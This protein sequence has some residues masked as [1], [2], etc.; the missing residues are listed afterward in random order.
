M[1]PFHAVTLG[2]LLQTGVAYAWAPVRV[3]KPGAA[4]KQESTKKPAPAKAADADDDGDAPAATER[5]DGVPGG[6]KD[7][8]NEKICTVRPDGS[9]EFDI[10]AQMPK[11]VRLRF[12]DPIITFTQPDGNYFQV[13][14]RGRDMLLIV[15]TSDNLPDLT[16]IS[17]QTAQT[18]VTLHVRDGMREG[19]DALVSI[20]DPLKDLRSAER[21]RA[22]AEYKKI[23]RALTE[24]VNQRML[25]RIANDGLEVTAPKGKAIARNSDQIVVR[26]KEFISMGDG[27]FL[28]FTIQNRS[29]TT[30]EF[31]G[32]RLWDAERDLS[33]GSK[34]SR[35]T[36]APGEEVRGVVEFTPSP[37]GFKSLRLTVDSSTHRMVELNDIESP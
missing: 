33:A 8:K 37:N 23:E 27:R 25:D 29:N 5:E 16:P 30:F 6:C 28:V 32:A 36:I 2:L 4:K 7:G 21:Q 26:G 15:P 13:L 17:V 10:Y 18:R 9:G 35:T 20:R 31:R 1:R 3:H 22:M 11:V 12:E 19:A 34:V 24:S 14:K